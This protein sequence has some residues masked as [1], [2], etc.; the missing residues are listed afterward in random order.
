MQVFG[1]SGVL[2]RLDILELRFPTHDMW[3]LRGMVRFGN[4]ALATQLFN[5]M[6]NRVTVLLRLRG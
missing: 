1:D 3:F 6:G 4:V 2:A 5:T